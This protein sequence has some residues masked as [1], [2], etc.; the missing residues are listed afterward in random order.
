MKIWELA[1]GGHVIQFQRCRMIDFPQDEY[2]YTMEKG[3]SLGLA[4]ED[5][6]SRDILVSGLA[7]PVCRQISTETIGMQ[8]KANTFR[9]QDD[10]T[11]QKFYMAL[12][13][14]QINHIQEIAFGSW[15]V[16]GARFRVPMS[17][18]VVEKIFPNL[19]RVYLPQH[20]NELVYL[21]GSS[22]R[23]LRRSSRLMRRHWIFDDLDEFLMKRLRL[24]IPE[25]QSIEVVV[26]DPRVPQQSL[27]DVNQVFDIKSLSS[28]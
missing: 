5:S 14:E 9:F 25:G 20:P 6:T 10:E 8:Y 16:A 11:F 13:Q 4:I 24:D 17:A 15:C 26:L 22:S 3:W 23:S 21:N 12:S 7:G 19:Q 27:D 2:G 18:P 1:V 28:K